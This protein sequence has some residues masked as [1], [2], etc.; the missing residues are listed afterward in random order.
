[1]I[2]VFSGKSNNIF[3]KFQ[4]S[5]QIYIGNINKTSQVHLS[6]RQ[7]CNLDK[8]IQKNECIH[9]NKYK[10]FAKL[11][12]YSTQAGTCLLF[13]PCILGVTI[14]SPNPL[15]WAALQKTLQ[16][17]WG[18]FNL[19]SAGC[20][21]ND[22]FDRNF[23]GKVERTKNRPLAAK[24]LTVP[25][26][27]VFTGTHCLLGQPVLFMIPQVSALQSLAVF[28]FAMLYPLSK[29]YTYYPQFVQGCVF[30]FGIFVG[31]SSVTGSLIGIHI[32]LPYYI[33]TISWTL[34]YD[35][36]YAYQD[37]KDDQTAGV[38][39]MAV[40]LG[41][42]PEA[43]RKLQL[44]NFFMHLCLLFAEILRIQYDLDVNDLYM[45]LSSMNIKYLG[46]LSTSF[47]FLNYRLSSLDQNNGQQCGNFFRKSKYFFIVLIMII[48]ISKLDSVEK[49]LKE[50]NFHAKKNQTKKIN[51]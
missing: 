20:G 27:L 41:T 47:A 8:P 45:I 16:Y 23:D 1:M 33:A 9:V 44:G 11:G 46:C 26:A 31:F 2:R 12:R 5:K 29:R 51:N 3:T 4:N 32:I 30:N 40:A 28:P 38:K 43:N 50:N 6:T 15:S 17:L 18:A 21:I 19:R 14:A 7:F 42:G 36:V 22:I 48:T 24:T 37:R 13:F 10:E 49:Q 25:E 39:G 34:I 35:T